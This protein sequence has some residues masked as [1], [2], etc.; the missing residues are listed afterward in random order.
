M[1]TYLYIKVIEIFCIGLHVYVGWNNGTRMST[2]SNVIGSM[3]R[4]DMVSIVG[5]LHFYVPLV[6]SSA[7]IPRTNRTNYGYIYLYINNRGCLGHIGCCIA[8]DSC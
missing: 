7:Y 6:I 8:H 5:D 3:H 2:Q 1:F 4:P